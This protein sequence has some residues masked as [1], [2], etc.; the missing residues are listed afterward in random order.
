MATIRGAIFDHGSTLIRRTGLDL[1]RDK[2]AALAAWAA[3]ALGY[4]DGEVLSARLLEI[5]LEGW[6]RSEAELV[7]YLGTWA[8]GRAF[9]AAGLPTDDATLKQAEA[10]FFRP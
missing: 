10:A 9:E 3:S 2:C 6:R 1:E 5:R 8:I 4:P 7:E